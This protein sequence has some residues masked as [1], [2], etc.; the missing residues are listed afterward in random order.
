[1]A[2]IGWRVWGTLVNFNGFRVLAS[3]LH[4]HRSLELNQTLHDVWPSPWLV[5]HIYNLGLLPEIYHV[6][7]SLCVQ[8]LRSPVLAALLHGTRAVVIS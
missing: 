6:Q 7:H 8:V 3:L 5:H 4:L 2:E 1:M